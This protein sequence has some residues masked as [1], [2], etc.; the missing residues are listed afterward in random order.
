[1]KRVMTAIGA[2]LISCAALASQPVSEL[3]KAI[4][5]VYYG[6]SDGW[7]YMPQILEYEDQSDWWHNNMNYTISARPMFTYD[8]N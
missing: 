2:V 1:M 3:R 5:M 8:T 6:T 4:L 7:F